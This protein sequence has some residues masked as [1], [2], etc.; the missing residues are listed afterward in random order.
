[1]NKFEEFARKPAFSLFGIVGFGITIAGCLI[2]DLGYRGQNYPH[3]SMFNYF[4]SE[5]GGVQTSELAIVFNISL[6]IGASL[7]VIFL[8]GLIFHFTSKIGK[9]G[10][11]VGVISGIMGALVGVYPFDV[12]I[13]AHGLVAMGFFYGGMFC[14]IIL[15][16]RLFLE[17]NT[18]FPGILKVIGIIAAGLFI[19]FNLSLSEF[20]QIFSG[21]APEIS[22]DFS[23]DDFRPAFWPMALFEWL[24]TLGVLVW[25]FAS[26]IALGQINSKQKK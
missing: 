6:I 17:K 25:I 5:L 7:M 8:A 24:A 13:M 2:T 21:D 18:P 3:Y 4:I 26:A 12:N 10:C 16:I 14:V 1:M 9:F 11:I 20:A 19:L 22:E 15:T 23:I